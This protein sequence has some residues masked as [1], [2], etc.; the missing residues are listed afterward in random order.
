MM[1]FECQVKFCAASA[2]EFSEIQFSGE[3]TLCDYGVTG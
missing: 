1:N 2:H 3:E